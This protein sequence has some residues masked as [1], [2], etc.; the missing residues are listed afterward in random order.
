VCVR[1][2][3]CVCVCVC[4]FQDSELSVTVPPEERTEPELQELA[5]SR[6]H[7]PEVTFSLSHRILRLNTIH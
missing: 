7:S 4:V 2:C 1:V 3:V 5:V 6:D